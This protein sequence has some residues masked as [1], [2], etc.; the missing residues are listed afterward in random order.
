MRRLLTLATIA[1][2]T[3]LITTT[4][5]FADQTF[6]SVRLSFVP[7]GDNPLR[8]GDVVDIHAN[9]PVNYATEEYHLNGAS[10]NATYVVEYL[11]TGA[12]F[13]TPVCGSP[14][15]PFPNGA[16]ITTDAT[17]SGNAQL[18]ISPSFVTG[19]GLHHTVLGLTWVLL[20]DGVPAYQTA[21]ILVGLD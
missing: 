11:I 1:C 5:A 10:P 18:K 16:T 8:N 12:P 13:G 3:L 4:S 9:G 15:V 6:H 20:Q 2:A 19:L 14:T 17:G 7:V 21:C